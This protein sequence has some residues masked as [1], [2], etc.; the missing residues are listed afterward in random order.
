MTELYYL[1]RSSH[2]SFEHPIQIP[3]V[4]GHHD[5]SLLY[6]RRHQTVAEEIEVHGSHTNSMLSLTNGDQLF[7]R[8]S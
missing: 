8:F 3:N 1:L 4:T 2:Q 5:L 6:E 7:H